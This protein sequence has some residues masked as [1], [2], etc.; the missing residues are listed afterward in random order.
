MLTRTLRSRILAGERVSG[1]LLRMPSEEIIEM[2]ACSGVD[3]I[4]L[5]CEHGPDD[6]IALRQHVAAAA[7]FGVETLVRVGMR[8][9]SLALRA[10]DA[11]ASGIVAP[12]VDDAAEAS[13]W[14]RHA[15]Y[16]PEGDRGFAL[17]SRA[18][19]YGSLS[20]EEHRSASAAGT[21]VVV[22]V[23]SP[24]SVRRTADIVGVPGVDAYMIGI[25]DLRASTGPADPPL[26]EA[27]ARVHAEARRTGSVRID[28]VNSATDATRAR[29][30]GARVI[31]YNTTALLADLFRSLP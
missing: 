19:G 31:V 15:R 16:R 17:Y 1:L 9:F 7:L 3:F 29:D 30:E 13:E 12:H 6:V 18:A 5:D 22:M 21:L 4:F 23:E 10:L 14:V 24:A 26:A 2:A 27:V 20:A 25:S 11:G 28:I 8:D